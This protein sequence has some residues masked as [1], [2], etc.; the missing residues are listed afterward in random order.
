VEKEEGKPEGLATQEHK[1]RS[2]GLV[3]LLEISESV[4]SDLGSA[5]VMAEQNSLQCQQGLSPFSCL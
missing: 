5:Y 4:G 2:H 3:G 1:A